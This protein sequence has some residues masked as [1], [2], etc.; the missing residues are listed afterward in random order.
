M[1]Q[2]VEARSAGVDRS[3][4]TLQA[5]LLATDEHGAR[6]E[7]PAHLH[8]DLPDDFGEAL[9]RHGGLHVRELLQNRRALRLQ[10]LIAPLAAT[11]R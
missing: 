3:K 1:Q 10:Q 8:K 2:P 6:A 9:P 7:L 4:P 5:H 11:T